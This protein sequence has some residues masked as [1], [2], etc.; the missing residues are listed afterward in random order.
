M[1]YLIFGMDWNPNSGGITVLHKLANELSKLNEDTY[2]VSNKTSD[3]YDTKTVSVRDSYL[4]SENIDDCVVIYPEVTLSNVLNTKNVV[5]WVLYYPGINGGPTQYDES[6]HVFLFDKVY[7]INTYYEN[8]PILN[9]F[10]SKTEYFYDMGLKRNGDCFLLRKGVYVHNRENILNGFYIDNVVN[11]ENSDEIL[12]EIFNKYERFIS[13]DS[14]S[15]Y[16]VIAA[17]CGCTSIVIEDPN[18]SQEDFYRSEFTK[19]GI[20]YG[21][22][23]VNRSISTKHL[24][25]PHVNMLYEKSFQ[26]VLNFHKYCLSNFGSNKS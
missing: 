23:N 17:M 4:L 10:E 1:R 14:N 2:I 22:E 6:E 5:R 21:M 20:I 3:K 7:G 12:L 8:N 19:Y 15:Y 11:T 26:T 16:S 25:K 18:K 24:V 9:I 13:Y